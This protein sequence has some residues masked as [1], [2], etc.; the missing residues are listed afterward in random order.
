MAVIVPK[1]K[2][3][4]VFDPAVFLKC[5]YA[6]RL[7]I[8]CLVKHTLRCYHEAFQTIPHGVTVLDYGTG[9]VIMSTI[10][11]ATK[12][13]EI[14]LSDYTGNNRIALRQ[15][16][17]GERAAFDW[18]PHFKHVVQKLEGKNEDEVKKREELVRRL[19]KAVAHCDIT[20]DPCIEPDHDKLYD[21]V[22]SSLVMESTS[23]NYDEFRSNVAKLGKLTKPGGTV[24]Y[25]GV[26]NKVGSYPIGDLNFPNAHVTAE[27]AMKAFND[28][29]FQELVLE[30]YEPDDDPHRVFRFIRGRK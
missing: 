29:G 23:S 30:T 19:V 11:A 16:L 6:E 4:E 12:A 27:F 20:K 13:S 18:S 5:Y 10:S 3:H 15:W 22:I 17:D 21:V 26:E 7:D 25:Y 8:S 14:V 9:P 24:L 28:A 1:E 2:Y